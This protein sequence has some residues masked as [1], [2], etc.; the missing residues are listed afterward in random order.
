MSARFGNKQLT[1]QQFDTI[2]FRVIF[3]ILAR[4]S[5]VDQFSWVTV[6]SRELGRKALLCLTSPLSSRPPKT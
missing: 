5:L 1:F 6:V 2:E 4:M 3:F